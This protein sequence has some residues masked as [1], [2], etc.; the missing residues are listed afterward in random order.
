MHSWESMQAM[1][2]GRRPIAGAVLLSWCCVVCCDVLRCV[3]CFA[4]LQAWLA[5]ELEVMAVLDVMP[6]V[7]D[8]SMM[9]S[10][11]SAPNR[12][13]P[14]TCAPPTP[15][16]NILDTLFTLTAPGYKHHPSKHHSNPSKTHH[17]IPV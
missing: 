5:L 8:A 15:P 14:C 1:S 6:G 10:A 7:R 2:L 9:L 16:Q 17:T 12:L 3:Q 11:V 13:G 4:G